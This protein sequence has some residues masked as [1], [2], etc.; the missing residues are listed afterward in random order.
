MALGGVLTLRLKAIADIIVGVLA[1]A[2]PNYRARTRAVVAII[3][4]GLL[5]F[6]AGRIVTNIVNQQVTKYTSSASTTQPRV[7]LAEASSTI[8]VDYAPLGVGFGQFGSAP[9][10]WKGSYSPI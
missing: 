8:A 5:I 10:I 7:R 6:A 9:S 4:G 2:A 1:L 3:V